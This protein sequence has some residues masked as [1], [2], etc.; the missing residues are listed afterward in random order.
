MTNELLLVP[1][2]ML[3]GEAGICSIWAMVAIA[4]VYQRNQRMNGWQEPSPQAIMA[5]ALWPMLPDTSAGANYVFSAEDLER[6][7]VKEIVGDARPRAVWRCSTG[8][9]NFYYLEKK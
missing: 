2:E 9:L 4:W 8:A 1:P 5:S 6:E 3:M 7:D